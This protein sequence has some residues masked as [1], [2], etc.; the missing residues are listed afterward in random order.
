M[1]KPFKAREIHLTD[2]TVLTDVLCHA[3]DFFLIVAKDEDDE[4]T[5]YSA[6]TVTKMV[7]VE[8]QKQTRPQK[9]SWDRAVWI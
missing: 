7:G 3:A 9:V 1:I 5:W 6:L 2:G 4:P 8:P